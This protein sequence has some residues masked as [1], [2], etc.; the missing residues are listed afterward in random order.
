MKDLISRGTTLEMN[1]D[2]P[3]SIP[4][5]QINFKTFFLQLKPWF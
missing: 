4:F 2:F 5:E 1:S 3:F